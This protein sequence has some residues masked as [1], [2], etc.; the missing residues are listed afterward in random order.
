MQPAVSLYGLVALRSRATWVDPQPS[1]DAMFKCGGEC[2]ALQCDIRLFICDG[3][4]AGGRKCAET[5]GRLRIIDIT[6]VH[7][8]MVICAQM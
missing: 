6:N 7:D 8:S 2:S 4:I 3:V 1:D 5:P